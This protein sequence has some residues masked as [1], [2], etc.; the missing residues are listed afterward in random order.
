M[1]MR[2]FT[3]LSIRSLLVL[4]LAQACSSISSLYHT[5]KSTLWR[6]SDA[7]RFRTTYAGGTELD[8]FICSDL[9]DIGGYS[10]L[11]P[12]GCIT[13]ITGMLDGAGIAGFGPAPARVPGS[14]PPLP[15]FF[16]SLANV[17]GDH[18]PIGKPV[19]EPSFSFLTSNSTAE[20]Q[21]GG[22]DQDAI[23]GS[24]KQVT[25]LDSHS[26]SI[27]IAGMSVGGEELLQFVRGGNG[28]EIVPAILDSGTTCMCLPDSTR[29]GD[30]KLSP[31]KK[32]QELL[33]KDAPIVLTVAGGPQVEISHSIWRRGVEDVKG[34]LSRSC[35]DDRIVLGDWMFQACAVVFRWQ[36]EGKPEIFLAPRNPNYALGKFGDPSSFVGHVKRQPIIRRVP[37]LDEHRLTFLVPVSIGR[38]P[39][40][41]ELV[42]DTGSSFFGVRTAALRAAGSILLTNITA[43]KR[44]KALRAIASK[45]EEIEWRK[46]KLA[47]ASGFSLSSAMKQREEQEDTGR[48]R[49]GGPPW[50]A[51]LLVALIGV[52]FFVLAL[53]MAIVRRR[54]QRGGGGKPAGSFVVGSRI[55]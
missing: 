4:V 8:G 51:G 54:M 23:V 18:G 5:S 14:A 25:S 30:L 28:D 55:T 35:P 1:P 45:A 32:F 48:S 24:L 53:G 49:N 39:Q 13:T 34:C 37:L 2:P 38:P 11:A 46:R 21:L 6:G 52:F 15:P 47:K 41:F 12:F 36:P 17:S 19:P 7:L 31:W 16:L 26:Y 50:W 10:S 44:A 43:N 40:T 27:P 33:G 9:I 3:S 42:F 20:L 29:N 22:I